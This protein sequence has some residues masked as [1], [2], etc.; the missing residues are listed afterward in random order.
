MRKKMT[1][2]RTDWSGTFVPVVTPFTQSGELDEPSVRRI[3]D[4]LIEE[5]VDGIVV[6]A[7]TGE[8]FALSNDE[9]IRLFEI[10]ADQVRGRATLLAGTSAIATR[11]AVVLTEA[12]RVLG[13]DGALILPPPYVLPSERETI[14]FFAAIAEVGLPL[15]LY[16]NPSRTQVNLNA[17][18]LGKLM[19][20]DAVVAL[21]DKRSRTWGKFRRRF[22]PG[23]ESWPSSPAWSH[24][25]PRASSGVLS[26]I[27]AMAPNVH[28]SGRR[29]G[30]RRSS[31]RSGGRSFFHC[32]RRSIDFMKG[33]TGGGTTLTW[34]SRRR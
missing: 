13:L 28:G 1:E 3:L 9:R 25:R 5:G 14:A 19:E 4:L 24:T 33:C 34:S 11:D 6:A 27:V 12:A 31:S 2:R 22:V 7:S 16:N 17:R 23:K 18:L 15:M 10:A 30:F 29:S 26:G 32:K 8:W 21:K 20:F